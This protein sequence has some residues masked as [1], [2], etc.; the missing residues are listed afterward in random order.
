MRML[1]CLAL[2]WSSV[3][4]DKVIEELPYFEGP[5]QDRMKIALRPGLKAMTNVRTIHSLVL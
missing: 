5:L 1:S 3:P 4:Q 2:K